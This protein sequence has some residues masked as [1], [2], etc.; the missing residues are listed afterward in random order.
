[1]KKNASTFRQRSNINLSI[2]V[3]MVCVQKMIR[4]A[5]LLF[6]LIQAKSFV[7]R[8]KFAVTASTHR[9]L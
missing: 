3:M 5:G 2:I 7:L 4:S 1:M 8:T 9:D 6:D